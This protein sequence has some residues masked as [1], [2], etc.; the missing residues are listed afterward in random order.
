MTTV[1]W[2]FGRRVLS[3]YLILILSFT[4][5]A[6]ELTKV[7]GIK[8]TIILGFGESKF[9]NSSNVGE[10]FWSRILWNVS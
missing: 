3:T 9:V 2:F 4:F 5:I 1:V 6:H 10:F 7:I 8:I